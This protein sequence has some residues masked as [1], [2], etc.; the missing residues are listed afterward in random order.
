MAAQRGSHE[1]LRVVSAM[2]MSKQLDQMKLNLCIL[3]LVGLVAC[4]LV[5]LG[6]TNSPAGEAPPAAAAPV[7]PAEAPVP[8]APK[9]A[10][11]AQPGAAI[12]L[13]VMDDVPLTD[14][15]RNLARQASLNYLLDPK[16]GFGQPGPDGKPVPQPSV[17]IRWENITAEQALTALLNNYSLQL[18][19]DSKSRI[20]RVTAKDPAAAE[21]LVTRI[22]QLKYASP[23]NIVV[24][25]QAAFTDKRSKVLPDYRTSQLVVVATEKEMP[26]VED[27]VQHLDSK[28]KQVLIEARLLETSMNPTTSKGIDWSGTLAAQH[29]SYG[30]GILSGT[31]SQNGNQ[32]SAQNS[33]LNS[34]RNSGQSASRN[35]SQN[36]SQNTTTTSPGAAITTSTTL[37]GGQTITTTTTPGSDSSSTATTASSSGLS[38]LASSGLSSLTGAAA[39]GGSSSGISSL[40][41]SVVGN[42]GLSLDSAR[43]LNPATFFL[44]ADGV[45]ATLSF[46]NT[47]AET[48]IISSP[49]TVTLDNEL[50]TIE[51]GTQF[52][53]VNTT[54]GT[55]NTTG[56][57]Q[58][59]YSNLTVRLRVVPRISANDYVR[60]QVTPS[61]VR[62]GDLITTVVGGVP[63]SVYSF[64]TREIVTSVLIPSGNT[65]VM[66]GLISD[67]IQNGNTKVPLLGDLPI[68]GLLFRSD[69]KSR[70]KSN[71]IVFITPTIVEEE[72]F[73]PTKSN[74]LK[75]KVPV[76]D[77]LE[78]D[79]SAWD[80]GKPMNWT[81]KMV[82]PRDPAVDDNSAAK[83]SGSN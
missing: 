79:W 71:L 17:S 29:V 22:I 67:E 83:T 28:T 35:S 39:S 24:N 3:T 30:N 74:F 47:Y 11:A 32:N 25:V 13:I 64:N 81:K 6:Q 72:D 51:V 4:T 1:P 59:T 33:S 38:S 9:P 53:I 52:P 76:K 44:N 37:P 26:E 14:A 31:I 56:G 82:A 43:G 58:I 16:I 60:L 20:A 36:N 54:A 42:G 49:R 73:Q 66:G 40:L 75:S 55:A 50:A 19:E 46:L 65:L 78:G 5:A 18:I 15:I 80:S 62:L 8:A 45:K 77:S 69:T 12:P 2:S 21:P 23:S 61:V 41:N 63:N 7:V 57:S 10:V 27:M 34:S 68:L 48:K 70:N